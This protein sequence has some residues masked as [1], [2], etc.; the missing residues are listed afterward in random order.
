MSIEKG[1]E[2]IRRMQ[3]VSDEEVASMNNYSELPPEVISAGIRYYNSDP[4]LSEA[5]LVQGIFHA[6]REAMNNKKDGK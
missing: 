6:M 4:G 5:I 2:A 1:W 3:A